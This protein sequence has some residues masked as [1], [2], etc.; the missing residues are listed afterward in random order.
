MYSLSTKLSEADNILH[1]RQ[2]RKPPL[3][4]VLFWHWYS[5][6]IELKIGGALSQS[7]G[8]HHGTLGGA[9][10]HYGV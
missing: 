6:L 8:V 4:A 2:K 10:L 3:R 5:V 7:E 9:F 1:L